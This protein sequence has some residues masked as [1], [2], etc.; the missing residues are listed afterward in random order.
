MRYCCRGMWNCLS[1]LESCHISWRWFSIRADSMDFNNNLSLT[2]SPYHPSSPTVLP[3]YILCLYRADVNRFMLVGQQWNLHV[4]GFIEQRHLWVR[5]SFSI[6]LICMVLRMRG[7][8]HNSCF[9]E[10][11]F[12]YLFKIASSILVLIPSTFFLHLFLAS[13]KCIYT[14]KWS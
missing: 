13:M 6:R 14:V 2:V 8:W 4:S 5:L 9:V 12:Q 7:K 10:C 1:V 3:C 11:C